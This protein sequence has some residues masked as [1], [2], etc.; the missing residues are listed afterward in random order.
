MSRVL[1]KTGINEVMVSPFTRLMRT[2]AWAYWTIGIV[3]MVISWFFWPSPAVALIGVVLL[4]AATRVGLPPIAVAVAMNLF[5]HGIAL[6]GDFVIQAAPKLTADAAGIPISD[7]ISASVPLVFV[8]GAVTTIIAF[9]MIR[10]DLK[11]GKLTNISEGSQEDGYLG[12]TD[13]RTQTYS[14]TPAMRKVMAVIITLMYLIDV[15]A[16]YFLKLQG[17]DATALLGGTSIIILVIISLLAHRNNGLEK[18]TEYLIDGFHFG[19][20]VF[21]PVIPIAAFF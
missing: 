10:R 19:F 6:S 5:G 8:M 4:P 13:E 18:I 12:A 7:V 14:L 1:T 2:P 11:S 15:L 21:G 20:K 3:M 16:M 17:G 9:W